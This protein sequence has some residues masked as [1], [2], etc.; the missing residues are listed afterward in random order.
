[1]NL[2]LGQVFRDL[3]GDPQDLVRRQCSELAEAPLGRDHD[4]RPELVAVVGIIQRLHQSMDEIVLLHL[5]RV[6]LGLIGAPHAAA[7]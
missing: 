5:V 3:R 7:G 4:Q 1:V 2:E 6:V